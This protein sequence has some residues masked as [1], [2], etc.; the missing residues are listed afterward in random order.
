M[1]SAIVIATV[2][3]L[4]GV[5]CTAEQPRKLKTIRSRLLRINRNSPFD[6]SLEKRSVEAQSDVALNIAKKDTEVS[7]NI[8]RRK[9]TNSGKKK[10]AKAPA[11]KTPKGAKKNRITMS[12]SIRKSRP[13]KR[14]KTMARDYNREDELSDFQVDEP[15]FFKRGN[16]KTRG[17]NKQVGLKGNR[18][19]LKWK[20]VARVAPEGAEVVDEPLSD[21][22]GLSL[23]YP[24]KNLR[25]PFDEE[26]DFVGNGKKGFKLSKVP[27]VE[28]DAEK[29]KNGVWVPSKKDLE[30][31][32]KI[33]QFK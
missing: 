4:V 1:R 11:S 25:I 13:P 5:L 29:S 33:Q 27:E 21:K 10:A 28:S 20:S 14:L 15:R 23:R 19:G 6:I 26:S 8:K 31:I 2:L 18:R 22:K 12:D 3:L 16:R 30:K 24:S 17:A 9:T 7:L 32:K